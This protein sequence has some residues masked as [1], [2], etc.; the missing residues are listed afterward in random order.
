MEPLR[1]R[2]APDQ[3][4]EERPV[5]AIMAELWRHTETLVQQE[6]QLGIAHLERRT[7]ELKA[8]L[9]AATLSGALLYAGLL[10]MVAA[11]IML[12]AKVIDPWLSALIVGAVLGGVGYLLMPAR[13]ALEEPDSNLVTR[14]PTSSAAL[15]ETRT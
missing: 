14:E 5:G 3:P 15:K 7:A 6:L 8:S 12:L 13:R 9:L 11:V 1:T 4:G 2:G 10:A